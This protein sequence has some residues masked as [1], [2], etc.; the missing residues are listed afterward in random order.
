MG[1]LESSFYGKLPSP[2][3]LAWPVAH[4]KATFQ[5]QLH[6]CIAKREGHAENN[7]EHRHRSVAVRKDKI[8]GNLGN[9]GVSG[10]FEEKWLSR[11]R[12]VRRSQE[13]IYDGMDLGGRFG[14][15]PVFGC[16]I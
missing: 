9:T 13:C 14:E 1:T 6:P 3:P 10:D 2:N 7:D 5:R 16:G 11:I 15:V 12:C 8:R 4:K